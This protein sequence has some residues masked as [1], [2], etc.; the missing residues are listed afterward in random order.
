M[1]HRAGDRE[2]EA[3]MHNTGQLSTSH[4]ASTRHKA[5]YRVPK[6]SAEN[7]HPVQAVEDR[8]VRERECQE[9]TGLSR[10]TRWRMERAGTFPKRRQISE[11][12]T[13]WFDSE[14]TAWI[15]ARRIKQ[16][17]HPSPTKPES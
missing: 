15:A 6:Q 12:C 10:S 5:D 7:H 17:P 13:G 9:R 4:P 3:R 14:V 8:I 11:R 16:N 2:H 1:C